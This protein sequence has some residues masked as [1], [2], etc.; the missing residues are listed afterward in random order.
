MQG[1]VF[2][3]GLKLL[4]FYKIKGYYYNDF[5]FTVEE[6]ERNKDIARST[7]EL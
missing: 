1:T 4:L 3:F 6:K 5:V 2:H 7:P